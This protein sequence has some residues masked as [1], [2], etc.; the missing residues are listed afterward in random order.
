MGR[1]G[2]IP[3]NIIRLS[4]ILISCI[5]YGM[6]KKFYPSIGSK[7]SSTADGC[8]PSKLPETIIP[9]FNEKAQC[10][11]CNNNHCPPL[12]QTE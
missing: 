9:Y 1:V 4:C 7:M 10:S 6:V 12:L 3:S 11:A 2:E 5:F 8:P